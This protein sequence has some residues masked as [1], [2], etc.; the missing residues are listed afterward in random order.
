MVA[1][2]L[3]CLF[4]AGYVWW[5]YQVDD[6]YVIQGKPI[7]EDVENVEVVS[8]YDGDTLTINIPDWPPVVGEQISVRVFGIDTPEMRGSTVSQYRMAVKA[9]DRLRYLLENAK[10]VKLHA[11]RRDK[12]FR[13]LADV[14][15]DKKNVGAILVGEGLAKPYFG[16]T[17]E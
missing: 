10:N 16:G 11:V 7:F 13:L 15:A 14:Y 2:N 8:V 3:C 12:Y 4:V 1:F 5:S 9:R 17:K 6:S